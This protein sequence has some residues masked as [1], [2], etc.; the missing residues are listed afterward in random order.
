[1]SAT[2]PRPAPVPLSRFKVPIRDVFDPNGSVF[3]DDSPEEARRLR[4]LSARPPALNT[5]SDGPST[6]PS[7]SRPLCV[8]DSAPSGR[9]VTRIPLNVRPT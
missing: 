9:T 3:P 8:G 5:P 6:V 1:M 2:R 7:V 4:Y